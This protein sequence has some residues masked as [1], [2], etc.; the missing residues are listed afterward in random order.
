MGFPAIRSGRLAVTASEKKL[1][2]KSFSFCKTTVLEMK[3]TPSR[4]A[5][6]FISSLT[7]FS[8]ACAGLI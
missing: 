8:P 6:F 7:L 3:S 4:A 2:A 5:D 1:P